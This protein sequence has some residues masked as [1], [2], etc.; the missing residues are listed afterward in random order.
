MHIL[1][2]V[3]IIILVM[4]EYMSNLHVNYFGILV[5]KIKITNILYE[6]FDQLELKKENNKITRKTWFKEF[7]KDYSNKYMSLIRNAYCLFFCDQWRHYFIYILSRDNEHSCFYRN[8]SDLYIYIYVMYNIYV[9][10]Y[11]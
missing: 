7:S 5:G 4:N 9:Y 3:F 8:A 1:C 11:I 2:K 6:I 10:M